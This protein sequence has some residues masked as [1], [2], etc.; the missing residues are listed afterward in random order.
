MAIA[1]G[2]HAPTVP[3]VEEG[4]PRALIFYKVTCEVTQE[5]APLLARFGTAYPGAVV[6]VG[7]DPR[8]A[9]DAFAQTYGWD[10]PQEPDLA[11]YEASDAYGI[12]SAPTVIVVD[13]EDRVADVVES[14]DRPGMNRASATL[15]GLVG[16]VPVEI[17]TPDD[18]F[19]DFKPG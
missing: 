18:G 3:G 11:P 19:A 17:S 5:V 16:A 8:A 4:R 6:G 9:L 12:A 10:F 15:A 1:V 13:G 7:Q 14:W 2:A